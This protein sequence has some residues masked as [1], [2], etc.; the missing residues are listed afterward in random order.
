[1]K[2]KDKIGHRFT[3]ILGVLMLSDW[4]TRENLFRPPSMPFLDVAAAGCVIFGWGAFGFMRAWSQ[5]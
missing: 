1:M 4:Y 5:V 3:I 2:F